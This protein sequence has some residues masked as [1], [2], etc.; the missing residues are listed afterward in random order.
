MAADYTRRAA[1]IV[2]QRKPGTVS[3]KHP[4]GE[5]IR[6]R[7]PECENRKATTLS[8]TK[9]EIVSGMG[10]LGENRSHGSRLRGRYRRGMLGKPGA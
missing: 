3:S 6:Q 4:S 1:Y 7:H 2:N 5:H 8:S 9:R 10:E